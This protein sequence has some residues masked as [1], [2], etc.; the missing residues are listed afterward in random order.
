MVREIGD[1]PNVLFDAFLFSVIKPFETVHVC[2]LR[3]ESVLH[4]KL[5]FL[6]GKDRERERD[7]KLM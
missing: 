5:I 2:L 3:K 7:E 4:L 6:L 1:G